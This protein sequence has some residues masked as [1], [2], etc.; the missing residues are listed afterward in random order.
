[1]FV[2]SLATLVAGVLLGIAGIIFLPRDYFSSRYKP[3]SRKISNP[4]IRRTYIAVKNVTGV[5]FI[6]MGLAMLLLPGQGLLTIAI[7]LSLTDFPGKHKMV[8]HLLRRG[9]VLRGANWLRIKAGK[10]PLDPFEDR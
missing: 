6:L 10:L 3:F 9:P 5:L 8:G 1:M 2:I 4:F 7:G